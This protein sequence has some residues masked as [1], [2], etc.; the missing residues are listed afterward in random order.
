MLHPSLSCSTAT[1]M[2]LAMLTGSHGWS[3]IDAGGSEGICRLT[4]PCVR[5]RGLR[6][7]SGCGRVHGLGELLPAFTEL[8]LTV[9]EENG[10]VGEGQPW[11]RRG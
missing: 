6:A 10:E 9:G 5:V 4:C 3:S 8:S 2:A 11:G 1:G 7:A